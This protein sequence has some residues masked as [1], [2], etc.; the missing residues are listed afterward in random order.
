MLINMHEPHS[1]GV[2]IITHFDR[3]EVVM[4]KGLEIKMETVQ[5]TRLLRSNRQV[6]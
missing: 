4:T 1:S 2:C 3:A 5:Q 6:F